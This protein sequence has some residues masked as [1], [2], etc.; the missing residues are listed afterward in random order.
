MDRI[1]VTVEIDYKPKDHEL[2]NYGVAL[3][4]LA[5]DL[6][7]TARQLARRHLPV[8]VK[9]TAEVKRG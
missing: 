2:E 4:F 7:R 8:E 9:T 3:Q 6:E 5:N 1:T